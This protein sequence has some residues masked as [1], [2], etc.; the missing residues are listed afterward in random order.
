MNKK[1][2]LREKLSFDCRQCSSFFCA[3]FALVFSISVR[4]FFI[5]TDKNPHKKDEQ[6]LR[7]VGV[8]RCFKLL[9]NPKKALYP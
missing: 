3:F 5:H 6:T 9:K 4:P 8:G 1:A 7:A 2:F